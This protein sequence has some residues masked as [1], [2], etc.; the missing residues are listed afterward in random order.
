MMTSGCKVVVYLEFKEK[1]GKKPK[2]GALVVE[3]HLRSEAF[4]NC[5]FV[6]L[7]WEAGVNT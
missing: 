1:G 5:N 2:V 7:R 3:H 6:K 4:P